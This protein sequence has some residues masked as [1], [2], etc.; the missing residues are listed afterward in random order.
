MIK[1]NDATLRI[2][3]IRQSRNG[4]FC[5]ADL[6]TDIGE[7]KVKDPILEQFD[8]GEYQATVWISEIFLGQYISYG[9]AVTEIRA[10]LHDMH[11]Q[12]AGVLGEPRLEIPEPDP[13]DEP[14]PLRVGADTHADPE[15]VP[16]TPPPSTRKTK[17]LRDL[18]AKLAGINKRASKAGETEAEANTSDAPA[19]EPVNPVDHALLFGNE[20]WAHIQGRT[21]VKLDPT[22]DRALLRRQ[23]AMMHTLDYTFDPKRQAWDPR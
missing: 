23:T 5:I 2:K 19:A 7:F 6:S 11:V 22:V 16:G 3:K 12:S 20:I 17:D 1:I 10:R 8:E 9:K 21:I 15:N 14:A 13:L 18:K 4:A